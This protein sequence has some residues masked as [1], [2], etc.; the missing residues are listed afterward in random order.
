MM[1][2]GP[3]T[4]TQWRALAPRPPAQ[5]AYDTASVASESASMPRQLIQKD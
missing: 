1:S 2:G 4:G 5:N 3:H